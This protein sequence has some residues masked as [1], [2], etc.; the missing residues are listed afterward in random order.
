[1]KTE[2]AQETTGNGGETEASDKDKVDSASEAKNP[3]ISVRS[4]LSLAYVKYGKKLG[5][6]ND[7]NVHEHIDSSAI[8]EMSSEG[9]AIK[10]TID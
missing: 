8:S 10:E 4:A 1:M 2:F 3:E 6:Q 5:M 9:N 7:R